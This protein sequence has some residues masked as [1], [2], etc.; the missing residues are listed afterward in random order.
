M[1]N[2]LIRIGVA[3]VIFWIVAYIGMTLSAWYLPDFIDNT[4]QCISATDYYGTKTPPDNNPVCTTG[5]RTDVVRNY[6]AIGIAITSGLVA[7][8]AGDY[9]LRKKVLKK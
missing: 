1:K 6:L 4:S 9:I 8:V 7:A 5:Y 3:V 2:V